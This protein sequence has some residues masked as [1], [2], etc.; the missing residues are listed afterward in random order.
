M[1]GQ[2][3]SML[4]PRVVGFKLKGAIPEGVTAIDVGHLPD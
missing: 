3:I 1:L 2:P 4:V